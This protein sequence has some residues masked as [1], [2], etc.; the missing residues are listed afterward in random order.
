M[1]A[2]GWGDQVAPSLLLGKCMAGMADGKGA[3]GRHLQC[4]QSSSFFF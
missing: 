3:Y 2:N 4:L 1:L